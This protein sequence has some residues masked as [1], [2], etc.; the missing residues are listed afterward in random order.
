MKNKRQQIICCHINQCLLNKTNTVRIDV[1]R[2]MLNFFFRFLRW[3]FCYSRNRE[4]FK[5][6]IISRERNNNGKIE[7]DMKRK[8]K[9]RRN[10]N[11]IILT[12][13]K[14][15]TM[16]MTMNTREEEKKTNK[17][18]QTHERQSKFYHNNRFERKNKRISRNHRTT[19]YHFLVYIT[20]IE[21]QENEESIYHK[22]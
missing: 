21:R 7:H 11:K 20:M 6:T 12:R 5:K 22:Y 17:H 9:S 19:T 16:L 18:T 10:M 15:N 13:L 3:T 14:T 2:S 1:K 4:R 8:T